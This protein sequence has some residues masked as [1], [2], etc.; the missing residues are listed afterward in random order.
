VFFS[1]EVLVDSPF[2]YTSSRVCSWV[3]AGQGRAEA[4]DAVAAGG[5]VLARAGF[6]GLGKTVEVRTS[7]P[8]RRDDVTVMAL[9]WSATGPLVNLFPT[10]VAFLE[11]S[12]VGADQSRIALIGSY[13]AP[14]GPAGELLDQVVLHKAGQ[15][16]VRRWLRAASTA[17][18]TPDHRQDS[19]SPRVGR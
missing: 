18:T 15:V 9:R 13:K 2:E 5:R 6:A 12:A 1:E 10:L 19:A 17:A 7:Q 3:A 16:T 11:I 14:L 8:E 4:S